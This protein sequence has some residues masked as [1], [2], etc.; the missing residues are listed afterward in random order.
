MCMYFIIVFVFEFIKVTHFRLVPRLR[1][2]GALPPLS[3]D[4][5]LACVGDI[6]RLLFVLK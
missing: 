2:S 3:L 4:I 6:L 1:M 5:F